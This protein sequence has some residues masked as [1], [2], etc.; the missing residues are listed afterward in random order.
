MT[1]IGNEQS[2]ILS[3]SYFPAEAP[4]L[5]IS[6]HPQLGNYF[7]MLRLGVPAQAVKLKMLREGF[8]PSLLDLPQDSP[9]PTG[10]DFTRPKRRG[11]DSGSSSEDDDP[12]FD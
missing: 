4:G 7:K 3:N 1:R 12:E 10:M 6:D 2:N 8:E 11:A 5:K 9:L